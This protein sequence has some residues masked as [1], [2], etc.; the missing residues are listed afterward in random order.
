MRR[1]ALDV[2][3]GDRKMQRFLAIGVLATM[4]LSPQVIA[5]L[6]RVSTATITTVLLKKGLRN[7][8][9]RGARP[10]L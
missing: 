5:A 8:W 6:S 3:A 2:V 4:S 7:V 10:L 9:M 1:V